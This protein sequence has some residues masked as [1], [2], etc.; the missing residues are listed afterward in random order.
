M[1]NIVLLIIALITLTACERTEHLRCGSTDL[2]IDWDNKTVRHDTRVY[3]A[4]F[5]DE[6][7]RVQWERFGRN[8]TVR[9]FNSSVIPWDSSQRAYFPGYGEFIDCERVSG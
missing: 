1:K 5:S 7:N 4:R 8:H 2:F 6:N 9:D 3:D